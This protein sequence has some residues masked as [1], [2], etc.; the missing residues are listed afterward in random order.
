MKPGV[1]SECENPSEHS[2][3]PSVHNVMSTVS[4]CWVFPASIGV[5]IFVGACLTNT[6]PSPAS[7]HFFWPALCSFLPSGFLACGWFFQP[8]SSL[9]GFNLIKFSRHSA[10]AFCSPQSRLASKLRRDRLPGLSPALLMA[11]RG[12]QSGPWRPCARLV[13]VSALVIFPAALPQV[14][15]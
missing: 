14:Q 3:Y 5:Y 6:L 2:P 12:F 10:S 4:S 15:D 11:D 1:L 8:R 7:G 13:L 9:L